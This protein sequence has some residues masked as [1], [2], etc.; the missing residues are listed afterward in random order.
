MGK[1]SAKQKHNQEI[2]KKGVR[3]YKD[4]KKKNKNGTKKMSTFIK[5]AFA[6]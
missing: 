5:E 4:Y 6:K 1:K 3:A 2:F